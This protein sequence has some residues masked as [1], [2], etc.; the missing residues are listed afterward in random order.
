MDKADP[1]AIVCPDPC[2]GMCLHTE[3]EGDKIICYGMPP[4]I[5]TD[6]NGTP[7]SMRGAEVEPNERICGFF[8]PKLHS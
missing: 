6:E 4:S 2:C 5:L 8:K 3:T 7:Y 1:K